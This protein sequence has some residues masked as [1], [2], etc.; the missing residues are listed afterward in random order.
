[1]NEPHEVL[2]AGRT[3]ELPKECVGRGIHARVVSEG[4]THIL[5]RPRGECPGV[6]TARVILPQAPGIEVKSEHVVQARVPRQRLSDEVR[7]SPRVTPQQ[8]RH[9]MRSDHR[10]ARQALL[11]REPVHQRRLANDAV[12]QR[13]H[14]GAVARPA[15][16]R[17]QHRDGR[18]RGRIVRLD[19]RPVV[20]RVLEDA[21][22]NVALNIGEGPLR[23][24]QPALPGLGRQERH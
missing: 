23:V 18:V 21:L 19:L 17:V 22:L 1:M 9:R 13:Q 5:R 10:V 15:Q 3:V 7:V 8:G 20:E 16:H 2:V 4:Q 12:Q 11:P 14:L 24:R 6:S